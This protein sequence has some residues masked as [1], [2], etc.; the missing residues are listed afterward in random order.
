[1]IQACGEDVAESVKLKRRLEGYQ[2]GAYKGGRG[3]SAGE[4]ERRRH[5]EQKK[6][7]AAFCKELDEYVESGEV[8]QL[9]KP[10]QFVDENS[11]HRHDPFPQKSQVGEAA[12]ATAEQSQVHERAVPRRNTRSNK[13]FRSLQNAKSCQSSFH[14]ENIKVSSQHSQ[15][16]TIFQNT[17]ASYKVT[18]DRM[19]FCDG[20]K[21]CTTR[22]VCS[23]I[24]WVLMY[25]YKLPDQSELLHQRALLNSELESIFK[26][27]QTSPATPVTVI[28]ASLTPRAV[29]DFN[30]ST[31]QSTNVC[32]LLKAIPK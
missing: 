3:P 23:H 27:A 4:L 18:V 7:A 9:R 21:Y 13:F 22:D 20:C 11:S 30:N 29:K 12:S 32:K 6:Q 26:P 14:I 31:I 19:P 24:L 2:M 15:E 16:V 17:G 8:M 1:M 5:L 28:G 10:E 25:V